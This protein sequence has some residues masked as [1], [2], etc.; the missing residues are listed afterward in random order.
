VE[1]LFYETLFIELEKRGVR[2][3]L[4]GGLAVNLHGVPR[5]TADADILVD[6]EAGNVGALVEVMQ[7]IGLGPLVPV[8]PRDLADPDKRQ[9]W[10]TD[11]GSVVLQF[12]H[13]SRPYQKVDV[14]IYHP[15]PFETLWDGRKKLSLRGVPVW[16]ASIEHIIELK[17]KVDPPR[18]QD[19]SDI[20][21]L[22][23]V[24]A[25]MKARSDG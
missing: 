23:K 19:L 18:T 6:F 24:L 7:A 10:R 1:D 22:E 8:D 3:V 2:Y 13:A 5:V 12:A 15:L 14:F 11:K 20:K 21:V 9:E 16:V 25:I 4:C 17:K